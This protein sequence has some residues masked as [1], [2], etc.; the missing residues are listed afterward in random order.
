MYDGR[1]GRWLSIDPSSFK[2]CDWST[3]KAFNDNP[4]LYK[5]PD[6]KDEFLTII[7]NNKQTKEVTHLTAKTSFAVYTDGRYHMIDDGFGGYYNRLNWYNKETTIVIDIDEKGNR[8]ET[9]SSKLLT[10]EVKATTSGPLI[11]D[12][13]WATLIQF[14]TDFDKYLA[15]KEEKIRSEYGGGGSTKVKTAPNQTKQKDWSIWQFAFTRD[16]GDPEVADDNFYPDAKTQKK[17]AS[18]PEQIEKAKHGDTLIGVYG[19]SET[20]SWLGNEVKDTSSKTN[21]YVGP[22]NQNQVKKFGNTQDKQQPK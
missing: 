17:V 7:V 4:N 5:D 13:V 15:K 22:S 16:V 9:T 20:K 3:Y 1:Y 21:I 8:T 2:N 11:N 14:D 12:Q 10:D 18:T 19:N 6:G